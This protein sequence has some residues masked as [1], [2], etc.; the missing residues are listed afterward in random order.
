MPGTRAMTMRIANRAEAATAMAR[1]RAATA[2]GTWAGITVWL[3]PSLYL[4]V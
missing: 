3:S 4:V 2:S 1:A